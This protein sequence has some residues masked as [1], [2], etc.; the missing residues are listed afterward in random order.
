L[1]RF[2]CFIGAGYLLDCRGGYSSDCNNVA[3]KMD[4]AGLTTRAGRK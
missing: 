3:G 4:A 2:G 1:C